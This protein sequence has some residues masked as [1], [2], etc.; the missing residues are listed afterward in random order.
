VARIGPVVRVVATLGA[1][2][3][4]ALIWLFGRTRRRA[5]V[6][7]LVGP[8]GGDTIG[9]HVFRDAA[10]R[11]GLT[12]DAGVGDAGLV[13][14][15]A[16]LSGDGFDATR[17]HPLV[18]EFY[19]HTT[20]FAM[21]VWSRTYFPSSLAL[22]LLVKTISKQVDQLNFPLSPLDTARGMTSEIIL[23]RRADRTVRYAGWL[24][25][26][27]ENRDVLY[28]GFYLTANAPN[29]GRPCVKAVFPMPDGSA[30]VLLRPDIDSTGG[31]L[32]DSS[33]KRFGDA[34]FYRM[35]RRG[36]DLRVW[37]IRT[38]HERFRIYVDDAGTLRG[39]HDVRF[40]G[41]P[42]LTLHYKMF[43]VGPDVRK[44]EGRSDSSSLRP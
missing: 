4:Y 24:R 19:E 8:I 40:L 42:V 9:D 17:V 1:W 41:L 34:G 37:Y 32:L 20:R 31:L 35:Q 6:D 39:D 14:D 43:R 12:L 26:I 10:E 7:W 11:E 44:N 5:D 30:T 33:G 16:E 29:E 18:R 23:L 38:L 15:F 28:A 36:D 27:A 3:I 21:D 22:W 25:R 2:F 13:A